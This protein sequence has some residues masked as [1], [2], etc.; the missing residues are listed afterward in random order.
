MKKFYVWSG[1][2]QVV[3]LAENAREAVD[4]ALGHASGQAIDPYFFYVGEAGFSSYS[5]KFQTDEVLDEL[6]FED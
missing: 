6:G 1:S 2:L 3:L 5:Y 4:K